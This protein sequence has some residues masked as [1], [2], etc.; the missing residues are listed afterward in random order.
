MTDSV[1][2]SRNARG[3]AAFSPS[4]EPMGLMP[5]G[6]A[7]PFS[8]VDQ[9]TAFGTFKGTGT[10]DPDVLY[11][12]KETMLAPYKNLKRLAVIGAVSGGLFTITIFMAWFGIP[13]LIASWLLWRF[14]A[15]Q[16][17]N[18]EAGYARYMA[19]TSA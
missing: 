7:N 14:Q 15:K 18:V 4:E 6:A 3:A 9:Q 5:A 17:A 10:R 13:V 19:S 16:V 12:H 1:A 8:P 11:A 2:L